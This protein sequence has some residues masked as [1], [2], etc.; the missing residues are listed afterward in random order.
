MAKPIS[1]DSA[2]R[3]LKKFDR[4]LVVEPNRG[5]SVT[6]SIRCPYSPT[7]AS[8]NCW[9]TDGLFCVRQTDG[10]FSAYDQAGT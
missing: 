6:G 1:S 9:P 10:L 8:K 2:R 4:V 3:V 7:D 5:R